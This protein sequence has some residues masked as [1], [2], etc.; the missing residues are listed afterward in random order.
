[1][2]NANL[3]SS[4]MGPVT[5]RSTNITPFTP[6]A[7]NTSADLKSIR[8]DKQMDSVETNCLQHLRESIDCSTSPLITDQDA[9][10]GPVKTQDSNLVVLPTETVFTNHMG[11][12]TKIGQFNL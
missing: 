4:I 11:E 3:Y 1:M 6:T 10:K 8:R 5:R 9:S 12:K 7:I 2:C